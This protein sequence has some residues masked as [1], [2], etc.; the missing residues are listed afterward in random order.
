MRKTGGI[1]NAENLTALRLKFTDDIENSRLTLAEA[2]RAM[3]QISGLTQFEYATLLSISPRTLINIENN[4]GNPRL[5]TLEK[6]AAP[7]GL[8]VS[9]IKRA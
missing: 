2:T 3:R 5:S 6:L 4:H 1:K 7:F 9:F 8:Q